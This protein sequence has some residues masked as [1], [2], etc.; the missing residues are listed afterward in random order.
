MLYADRDPAAEAAAMAAARLGCAQCGAPLKLPPSGDPFSSGPHKGRY[1]C[2]DCWTLRWADDPRDLADERSRAY[3][4][5]EARRIRAAR[6]QEARARESG[7]ALG[8]GSEVL[9]E[10]GGNKAFLTEHGMVYLSLACEPG[11]SPDEFGPER[12]RALA[13]AVAAVNARLPEYAATAPAVA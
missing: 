9:H 1:L 4:A 2:A 13:A 5:E 10:D 11:R 12:W 8:R 6:A 3:V 7:V